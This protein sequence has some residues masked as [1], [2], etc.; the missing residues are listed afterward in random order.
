VSGNPLDDCFREFRLSA[1]RLEC[2]PAYSVHG[3]AESIQAWREG[4]PRPERSLRTSDYLRDVAV[5][6]L[7]GRQRA[8]VRVVDEPLSEYIRW[9]LDSYTENAVAGEEIRIAVRNGGDDK[10]QRDL[11]DVS[12]FWYFDRGEEDERAVLM[13]YE[14]DGTFISSHLATAVDHSWCR[15]ML[16]RA[17]KHSVPLNEYVAARQRRTTAA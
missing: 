15:R 1:I 14:A 5:D 8:R 16:A 11:A 6:V 3:E 12:D 9:E 2:L 7:N 10:A 4:L 17:W 13:Y